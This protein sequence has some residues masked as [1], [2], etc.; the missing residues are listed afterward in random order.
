VIV[1][2]SN[3]PVNEDAL[4]VFVGPNLQSFLKSSVVC[5]VDELFECAFKEELV[6]V[7][8]ETEIHLVLTAT[9]LDV[10]FKGCEA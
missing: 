9:D 4:E 1:Q 7:V 3:P 6:V 10:A 5:V 2:Y 8:C